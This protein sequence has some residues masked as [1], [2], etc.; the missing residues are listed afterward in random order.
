MQAKLGSTQKKSRHLTNFARSGHG[1]MHFGR[2]RC[3]RSDHALKS[4]N[5]W[6]EPEDRNRLT[7]STLHPARLHRALP[8][9]EGSQPAGAG[10]S[11]GS[12]EARQLDGQA[13]WKK[14]N[15]GGCS[16]TCFFFL[17]GLDLL[18]TLA[19]L[20]PLLLELRAPSGG[21]GSGTIAQGLFTGHSGTTAVQI[22]RYDHALTDPPPPSARPA[23]GGA[24]K[25]SEFFAIW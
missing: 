24:A 10:Q 5:L 1:Q 2:G 8:P 18:S 15:S 12:S 3:T 11:L 17:G 13:S 6:N 20:G 25:K 23:E 9:A 19:F 7:Q 4:D 22:R 21:G 14:R 16:G